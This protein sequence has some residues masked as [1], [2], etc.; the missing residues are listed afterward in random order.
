MRYSEMWNTQSGFIFLFLSWSRLSAFN[1]CF[2]DFQRLLTY[3]LI[4][5]LEVADY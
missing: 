5:F 1:I 3:C 2:V 4:D